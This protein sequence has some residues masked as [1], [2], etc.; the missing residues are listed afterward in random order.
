MLRIVT[1]YDEGAEKEFARLRRK[2]WHPWQFV[3]VAE[4]DGDVSLEEQAAGKMWAVEKKGGPYIEGFHDFGEIDAG[5]FLRFYN[6]A[7]GGN[8][9]RTS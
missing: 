9:S 3:A 2:K 8:R 7:P 4:V 1:A 6:A 5:A